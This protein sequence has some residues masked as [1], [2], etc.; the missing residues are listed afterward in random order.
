MRKLFLIA[1]M[2]LIAGAAFADFKVETIADSISVSE[3]DTVYT[4]SF[5]IKSNNMSYVGVAYKSDVATGTTS[6]WFEQSHQRPTTEQSSDETY[7]ITEGPWTVTGGDWSHA[8]IDTVVMPYGRFIIT[9]T[10][11]NP[12]TTTLDI[13]VSKE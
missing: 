5:P 4:K 7:K 9:G 13:K 1:I 6:I 2:V 8:T 11:S 3:T 10:G 12:K